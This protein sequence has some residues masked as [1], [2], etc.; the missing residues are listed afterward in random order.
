MQPREIRLISTFAVAP[1]G[2]LVATLTMLLELYVFSSDLHICT[3]RCV[4][5]PGAGTATPLLQWHTSK[6]L[7]LFLCEE[8][9]LLKMSTDY[10]TRCSRSIKHPW[11]KVL[12]QL[13]WWRNGAR[14]CLSWAQHSH[15]KW[16]SSCEL[17]Q[18]I[19]D[20][21][22]I[23][24]SVIKALRPSISFFKKLIEGSQNVSF[25]LIIKFPLDLINRAESAVSK[26]GKVAISMSS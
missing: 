8:I 11:Y 14:V 26:I 2:S 1:S 25:K 7:F 18:Y 3:F 15:T 22:H 10:A 12:E 24:L 5:D 17:L 19:F 20:V 21:N 6:F 9:V 13:H 16:V 23:D 4:I